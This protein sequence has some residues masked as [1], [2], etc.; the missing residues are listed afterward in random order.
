MVISFGEADSLVNFK[1]FRL[2]QCFSLVS[3]LSQIEC[4]LKRLSF[5]TK[6]QLY[7]MSWVQNEEQ[8]TVCVYVCEK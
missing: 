2:L 6:L 8:F 3:T 7:I 1:F 4:R 5:N